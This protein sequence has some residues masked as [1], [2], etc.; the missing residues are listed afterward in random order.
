MRLKRL[1]P[2]SADL[3]LAARR[4]LHHSLCRANAAIDEGDGERLALLSGVLARKLQNIAS[5]K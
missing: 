1:H 4:Q 2:L 3:K 5:V